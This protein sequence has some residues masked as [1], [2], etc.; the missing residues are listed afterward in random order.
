M[1]PV[2]CLNSRVFQFLWP[3]VIV[4]QAASRL[5]RECTFHLLN[6]LEQTMYM[7]SLFLWSLG[8]L[9][10]ITV[11]FC[12]RLS[13]NHYSSRA[14]F[15]TMLKLRALW[16]L[17]Y[18]VIYGRKSLRNFDCSDSIDSELIDSIWSSHLKSS[19]V[20]DV[21]D[22]VLSYSELSFENSIDYFRTQLKKLPRG[23]RW[24]EL[25]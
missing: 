22:F 10:D 20:E 13:C 14:P 25:A 9:T 11:Y 19:D 6:L 21:W 24:V 8:L 3:L 23:S 12:W 4:N 7:P 1:C 18:E 15:K 5:V 17:D 16:I 2:G